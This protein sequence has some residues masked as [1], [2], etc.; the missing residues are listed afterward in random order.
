MPRYR[1]IVLDWTGT[2]TLLAGVQEIRTVRSVRIYTPAG[3]SS[4]TALTSAQLA[5]LIVSPDGQIR[6]TDYLVFAE[7]TGNVV[8]EVE[9]GLDEPPAQLRRAAFTRLR[10]RLNMATSS[11]PERATNFTAVEGGTYQLSMPGVY[12]TGIPDVDAVYSRYSRR[13]R[14]KDDY[15]ASRPMNLDP[16]WWSLYHG[17][18]R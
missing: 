15:P 7:G 10:H 18:R 1:R 17:G 8:L 16:Q 12:A 2:D 6:R 14:D 13:K 5:G 9:H 11:V 3:T 4:Y